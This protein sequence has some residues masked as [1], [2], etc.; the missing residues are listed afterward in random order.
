MR[1]FLRFSALAAALTLSVA[2]G[3]DNDTPTAPAPQEPSPSPTPV[4]TPA[5]APTP[6]PSPAPGGI[7]QFFGAVDAIAP[8]QID[9]SGR[10]FAV[11]AQTRVTQSGDV[12]IP[13]SSLQLGD[14]V[15]V[16]ARQN[17]ANAWTALEIKRR[18]ETPAQVKIT[19]RVESIVAPDLTV[20][21]RLVRTDG[22]TAYT[23]LGRSLGEIEVGDLVTVTMVQADDG[24]MT[25]LKIRL[26][27]KG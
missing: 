20:S 27:A 4:G 6:T 8:D 22:A 18:I 5:P 21:G 24:V 7:E 3:D 10:I 25:A 19:G 13:Y 1:S 9:V 17:Q 14:L 11:T 2:C 15:L 16:T 12:T 26:E 23:G